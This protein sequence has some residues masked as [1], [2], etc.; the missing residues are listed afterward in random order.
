MLPGPSGAIPIIGVSGRAGEEDEAAAFEA[1]MTS[2]LRKP[3]SPATLNAALA[4]V[5]VLKRR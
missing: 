3:T 4:A 1:G 2:Y 5:A